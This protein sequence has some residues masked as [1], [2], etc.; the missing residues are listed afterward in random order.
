M[1]ADSQEQRTG[2]YAAKEY[3]AACFIWLP[4]ELHEQQASICRIQSSPRKLPQNQRANART[5]QPACRSLALQVHLPCSHSRQH[6][7]PLA[8]GDRKGR[9][10]V[11]QPGCAHRC[12][13]RQC[14]Y[15]VPSP[16]H[17]SDPRRILNATANTIS[18]RH[19]RWSANCYIAARQNFQHEPCPASSVLPRQPGSAAEVDKTLT[20]RSV[21]EDR[22]PMLF[23][24]L[25]P[26][27]FG[28][29]HMAGPWAVGRRA[30]GGTARRRCSRRRCA[31][32]G[33]PSTP[34]ASRGRP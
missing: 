16:C 17:S 19:L 12:Q 11:A 3:A 28:V 22:R 6:R 24:A 31:T 13:G 14:Q 1:H 7:Q 32:R 5:L 25:L 8:R 34:Q 9:L 21:V 10:S 23:D 18:T 15:P 30:C 33:R 2:R 20:F 26:G 27:R 4:H 29:L